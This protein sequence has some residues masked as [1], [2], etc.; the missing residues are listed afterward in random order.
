MM[1]YCDQMTVLAFLLFTALVA[2]VYLNVNLFIG[3]RQYDDDLTVT[4]NKALN[5]LDAQYSTVA[6]VT[7]GSVMTD[8]PEVRTVAASL[9]N[10]REAILEV[11]QLIEDV[12]IDDNSHDVLLEPLTYVGADMDDATMIKDVA[13]RQSAA[14]A[15]LRRSI[16]DTRRSVK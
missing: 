15:A 3:R 7:A 10:A 9:V 14:T 11:A 4:V 2:S 12:I 13:L 5:I 6:R 1:Y 16:S 8:T